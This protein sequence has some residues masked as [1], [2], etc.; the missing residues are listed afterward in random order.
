MVILSA[1]LMSGCVG[2]Q[3]RSPD[4]ERDGRKVFG[5]DEEEQA[6]DEANSAAEADSAKRTCNLHFPNPFS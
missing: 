6:S 4:L 5:G 2:V 1:F 3:D